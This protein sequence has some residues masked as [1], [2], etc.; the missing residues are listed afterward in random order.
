MLLLH[1]VHAE[2][3]PEK[4]STQCFRFWSGRWVCATVYAESMRVYMICKKSK[5]LLVLWQV[6][7]LWES[8][9]LRM[10]KLLL[11][12]W[13]AGR[14]WD[15]EFS[16]DVQATFGTLASWDFVALTMVFYRTS[17]PRLRNSLGHRALGLAPRAQA[18]PDPCEPM[19]ESDCWVGR[20][21]RSSSSPPGGVYVYLSGSYEVVL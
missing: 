18:M 6:G 11:A 2:T 5:L 7:T 16:D 8:M 13:Q 20:N 21:Y 12:L 9:F 10:S 1:T 14:S 19:P 15:S 4:K 3:M 17:S